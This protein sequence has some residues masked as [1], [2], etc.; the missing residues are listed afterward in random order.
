M[1]AEIPNEEHIT[2]AM[3]AKRHTAL[4]LIHRYRARKPHNVVC[5]YVRHYSK[6]NDMVMDPFCGSGVVAIEAISMGRK[7]IAIDLNPLATFITR[8]SLVS[9][10]LKELDHAFEEV[11]KAARHR[12]YELYITKCKKGH[13]AVIRCSVLAFVIECPNCRQ[14]ISMDK[15]LRPKGEKQNVYACPL[16]GKAFN[17]AQLNIK[18]EKPTEIKYYCEV[19]DKE[20]WR[21]TTP[22]DLAIYK[23][24][25][26]TTVPYWYPTLKL[27]YPTSKRFMTRRRGE[28]VADLFDRRNMIALSIL[29]HVIQELA[30]S[31]DVKDIFKLAFSAMLEIVSKLNPFRPPKSTKSG[32]TVHEYW[33]PAVHSLNNVWDAFEQRFKSVRKGKLKQFALKEAKNFASLENDANVLIKTCSSLDLSFLPSNS[34]EYVFTDPPYGGSIQYYELDIFRLA[35]LRGEH[36]DS[37]FNVDWWKDEITI[38]SQQNKSFDY[39]HNLL[40]AAF[41]EIFRVLKPRAYMTVTFHSTEVKVYNSII[42]AG[43]YAGFKMEHIVY[44]PPAVRSAK[45]SLHPYTSASGDYYIRFSK[46]EMP[47]QLPTEQEV[48][49]MRFET[50]VVDTVKEIIAKR[51]EPTSYNDIL[52]GIYIELDKYGYLLAAKPENI[53]RILKKHEGKDFVFIE[54]EGWWFKDPSEYLLHIVP[55]QDRVEIAV[56]Q[57]LKKRPLASFDD[58]LQEIFINFRNALTPNPPRVRAILEEYAEQT[59]GKWRLKDVVKSHETLHTRVIAILADLGKMLGFR[60]WVGSNEQTKIYGGKPLADYCDF[61]ELSLLG[62][63]PDKVGYIR[64]IDLLWIK[65][66][67]ISWAFEVEYTTAITEAFNRCSNIPEDH[68]A[69]K[70]IVIPEEREALLFR[71]LNSELLKQRAEKEGWRCAFFRDVEEIANKMESEEIRDTTVI[72][73]LLK[74]PVEIRGKQEILDS[75]FQTFKKT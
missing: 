22:N 58:I 41:K 9:V 54:G 30:A 62:V 12:I 49:M 38:N 11:E 19:C 25:E 52:K 10:D 63:L 65:E 21:H 43:V 15:A 35:W 57:A 48:D 20:E 53:E 13:P 68:G 61:K 32:W 36:E 47:R 70:V 51:G 4:Y 66:G 6:E 2:H 72:E 16:C 44:Q 29:W 8:T 64:Q 40:S 50:V 1:M 18:D 3:V 59:D 31:D 24:L 73:S 39:Y 46:P 69:R 60:I 56:L 28:T 45:A 42:R 74:S 34:V 33:V 17:Y 71:K 14:D 75:Y 23:K 67:K 37:R 27:S 26:D 7:V 55:L 5:E